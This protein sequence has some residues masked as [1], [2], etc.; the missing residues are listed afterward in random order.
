MFVVSVGTGGKEKQ[1]GAKGSK[2]PR[3]NGGVSQYPNHYELKKNRLIVLNLRKWKC[4]ICGEKAQQTHHKDGNKA[5]HSLSNLQAVCKKCHQLIHKQTEK[6]KQLQLA[7]RPRKIIQQHLTAN[8][9]FGLRGR[10]PLKIQK[11]MLLY[12]KEL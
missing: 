1:M 6:V 3:W 10:T 11:F 7:L 4:E 5:N 9:L 12:G 2:N 8:R